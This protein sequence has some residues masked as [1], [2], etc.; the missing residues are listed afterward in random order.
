MGEKA[1]T[2]ENPLDDSINGSLKADMLPLFGH[3]HGISL[4]NLPRFLVFRNLGNRQNETVH[5]FQ[6]WETLPGP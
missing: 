3:F 4:S 6:V 2:S 5:L 1:D